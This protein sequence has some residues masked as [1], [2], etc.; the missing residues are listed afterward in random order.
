MKIIQIECL[1][2]TKFLNPDHDLDHDPDKFALRK[3]VINFGALTVH[4]GSV[5]TA[6]VISDIFHVD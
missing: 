6:I 1:H 4:V 3:R 2:K 5:I